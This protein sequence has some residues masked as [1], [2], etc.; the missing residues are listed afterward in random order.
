MITVAELLKHKDLDKPRKRKKSK[1]PKA[2]LNHEEQKD[3]IIAAAFVAEW[4]KTI[5]EWQEIGRPMEQIKYAKSAL[6]FVFKTMDCIMEH[7]PDSE[8]LKVI[9]RAGRAKIT[10]EG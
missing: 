2:Y 4:Q 1:P 5:R 3:V 8:K 10:I 9:R 7:L 6:T